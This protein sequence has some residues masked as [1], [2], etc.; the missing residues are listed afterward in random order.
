MRFLT[1]IYHPN[2]NWS[3]SENITS[4]LMAIMVLMADPNPDD[5]LVDD[6]EEKSG[7]LSNQKE[8]SI[9]DILST[10][11]KKNSKKLVLSSRKAKLNKIS[12]STN[13]TKEDKKDISSSDQSNVNLNSQNQVL[14]SKSPKTLGVRR[15]S[16]NQNS[17]SQPEQVVAVQERKKKT[18]PSLSVNSDLENSDIS[19]DLPHNSVGTLQNNSS[20]E[21]TINIFV[22]ETPEA[23]GL[24]DYV[25]EKNLTNNASNTST[26]FLALVEDQQGIN[27]NTLNSP[28][29]LKLFNSSSSTLVVSK[30]KLS[31]VS[32]DNIEDNDIMNKAAPSTSPNPLD[33]GTS[34]PKKPPA[35]ESI[36][37]P[38]KKMK[39]SKK[40]SKSKAV[41]IFDSSQSISD[42][43]P[44]E[45]A[46]ENLSNN[47]LGNNVETP[48]NSKIDS[49]NYKHNVPCEIELSNSEKMMDSFT[50]N[51][52][53]TLIG[54]FMDVQSE[55]LPKSLEKKDGN[56]VFSR[57]IDIIS[58]KLPQ[59]MSDSSKELPQKSY[60]QPTGSAIESAILK[61]GERTTIESTSNFRIVVKECEPSY[62]L[63]K[64]EKHLVSMKDD[65]QKHHKK[66]KDPDS[67]LSVNNPNNI[68]ED[69]KNKEINVDTD[70]NSETILG[71]P[72]IRKSSKLSLLKR[73]LL[74]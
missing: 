40:K 73:K 66:S 35:S 72:P 38:T 34:K 12:D 45:I 44:I 20:C 43:S 24:V 3:P 62:A 52:E 71:L 36:D 37:T 59:E 2:G 68:N 41:K 39:K 69:I 25:R 8:K 61:S 9:K 22:P 32:K 48:N 53:R 4:I 56:D 57:D 70:F 1:P 60:Q 19:S 7:V 21:T 16:K 5:S 13:H 63:T 42:S 23:N 14:K 29:D 6:I 46:N 47:L 58:F 51:P 33:S 28:K 49:I 15:T 67:M 64:N 31:R 26:D 27:E 50:T 30:S 11:P 74:S 17:S 55:V 18:I 10:K 65:D 54:D